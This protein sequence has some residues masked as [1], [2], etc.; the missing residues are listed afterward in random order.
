M[1]REC[2]SLHDELE[3]EAFKANTTTNLKAFLDNV[4]FF[5]DGKQRDSDRQD[6]FNDG[7]EVG[8]QEGY[9][10]G[11]AA[12]YNKALTIQEKHLNKLADALLM[13]APSD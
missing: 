5:C 8:R 7:K 6:A 2:L 13:E 11:Y 9:T 4:L 3:L 10:A 1:E 12:G